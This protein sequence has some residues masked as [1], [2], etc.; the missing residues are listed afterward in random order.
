MLARVATQLCALGVD[1]E[2]DGDSLVLCES[3][4]ALAWLEQLAPRMGLSPTMHAGG[5]RLRV[6]PRLA[7]PELADT[8]AQL[9][10]PQLI[11]IDVD[12]VLIHNGASLIETA[13]LAVLELTK[14]ALSFEQLL[15]ARQ[16]GGFASDED[17]ICQ[18]CRA[19]GT[20]IDRAR[21]R[22]WMEILYRGT[23]QRPGT[24]A[25]ER[26]LWSVEDGA[27]L[28][29][30]APL[31]L[32]TSRTRAR[33]ELVRP[34]LNLPEG[35]ATCSRDD[36]RLPKPDPEGIRAMMRAHGATRA[37][38]IGDRAEDIAAARAAGVL[39]IGV[40]RS[41]SMRAG[42]PALVFGSLLKLVRSLS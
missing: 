29:R 12:G 23:P 21:A 13:R 5:L 37:W 3:A 4:P 15:S 40:G 30:I 31:A 7:P 41:Q 17:W 16:A 28:A 33:L 39:A 1:V 26:P 36:V 25:L 35:T 42:E 2:L 11:C 22:E 9:L 10:R 20:E 8:L 34:L 18:L 38:M 14:V 32:V 24:H 6:D 19:A 27:R